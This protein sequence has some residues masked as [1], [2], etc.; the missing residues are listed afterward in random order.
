[1]AHPY[2]FRLDDRV[3]TGL[4]RFDQSQRDRHR[5]FI[6]SQQNTDGGFGGRGLPGEAAG[7]TAE[8]K[9]S[10]LYY[11]AFAIRALSALR[12]FTADDARKIA[13][14]LDATRNRH[15]TVI[16]MVSRL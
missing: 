2:L 7:S 5:S 10:D 8:G 3:A 15:A 1:M 11:T 4:A 16:D 14:F 9:E 12:S 13:V 6:L